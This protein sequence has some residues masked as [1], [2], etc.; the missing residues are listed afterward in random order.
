MSR[1]A[2]RVAHIS[3]THCVPFRESI[4]RMGD[5]DVLIHSGD[6]T[7]NGKYG[8]IL[9]FFNELKLLSEGI[10]HIIYV[11]G[12]HDR[13]LETNPRKVKKWLQELDLP[14]NIHI[15]VERALD[16]DGY[17][18]Y[19]HPYTPA[20]FDWA[21]NYERNSALAEGVYRRVPSNTDVIITHGP[22]KGIL[23]R[24]CIT[25]ED[26]GCEV[27]ARSLCQLPNLKL[28]CF[29]HI[30]EGYGVQRLGEILFSNAAYMN[31]HY[32]MLLPN[33]PHLYEL[34]DDRAEVL[35][36]EPEWR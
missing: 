4:S 23:D 9:P 35:I 13:S 24:T 17:T 11:P 2:L 34:C 5:V 3:D 6:A 32:D 15:L 19:G 14:D 30:H 20:F 29:G 12:N 22:P 25:N 8:E 28:S 1:P 16:I 10:E 33:P 31:E 21:F 7:F 36:Y 27:F 18:F 26:V